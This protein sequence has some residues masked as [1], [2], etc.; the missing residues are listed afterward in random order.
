M[1]KLNQISIRVACAILSIASVTA[2][3]VAWASPEAPD[4]LPSDVEGRL[5]YGVQIAGPSYAVIYRDDPYHAHADFE[6]LK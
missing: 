3:Q 2:T 6:S 1:L 4:A 5:N